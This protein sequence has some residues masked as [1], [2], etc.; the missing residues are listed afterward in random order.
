MGE[1][2]S[3]HQLA[4]IGAGNIADLGRSL[5]EAFIFAQKAKHRRLALVVRTDIFKSFDIRPK[6]TAIFAFTKSRL[7]D[8][9]QA[10]VDFASRATARL[11][12]RDNVRRDRACTAMSAEF[13]SKEHKPET[14]RARDGLEPRSAKLAEGF[15]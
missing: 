9:E 4:A 10:Q 13:A 12:V 14:F 6:P 1:I 3:V 11:F 8:C 15:V 7:A 5:G 2:A